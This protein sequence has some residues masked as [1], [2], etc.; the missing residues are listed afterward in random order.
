MSIQ[1]Y[2][3]SYHEESDTYSYLQ[4]DE[5]PT[6][7]Y[8]LFEDHEAA[9]LQ[10]RA[11]AAAAQALMV[12]KAAGIAERHWEGEPEDTIAMGDEIRALAPDAGTA[13]LARLRGERDHAWNMVAE[14]DTRAIQAAADNLRNL[15]II[16]RLATEADRL[17]ME[18]KQELP[19]PKLRALVEGQE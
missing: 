14:S 10:A 11:D 17:Y 1:R 18:G 4:K 2:D 9:L 12:Q 6:G 3:I 15:T 7:E 13:E 5:D 19:G 8:V 16:D